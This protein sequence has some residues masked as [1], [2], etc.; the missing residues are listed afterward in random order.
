MEALVLF[1]E[2]GMPLLLL[3]DQNISHVTSRLRPRIA[4]SIWDNRTI[5]DEIEWFF[6]KID[7]FFFMIFTPSYTLTNFVGH[8]ISSF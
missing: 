1:S 3:W 5:F 7:W 2:S 8:I 4:I 6:D